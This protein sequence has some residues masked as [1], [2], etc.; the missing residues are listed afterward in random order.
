MSP[1]SPLLDRRRALLAGLA[2]L[3]GSVVG[4]TA[5]A[6]EPA[7]D[8][9]ELGSDELAPGELVAAS[10][11]PDP[12]PAQIEALRYRLPTPGGGV[13]TGGAIVGVRA[14]MDDVLDVVLRY[15]KY[16]H[17]LPR[18]EQSRVVG[19]K[20]DSADVYLRAPILGGVAT[21]WGIAR[22]T[23][24][25]PWKDKGRQVV[26]ELVRGNLDAFH[27]EWKLY[28]CGPSRTILRLELF[29]AVAIP[30]PSSA[31]TPELEWACDKA[32]SAVREMAECGRSVG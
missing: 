30:L 2:L 4:S 26:G 14:P 27:G 17:I 12:P 28:P 32:V 7:T 18:L 20:G 22:F 23:G 25:R 8:E 16:R 3:G 15:R 10:P 31:V 24:P 13:D 21:I 6:A 11:A 1:T 5:S 9:G 19:K 29:V